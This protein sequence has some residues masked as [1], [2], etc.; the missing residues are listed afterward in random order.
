MTEFDPTG[1]LFYND[2]EETGWL[3][4]RRV[5]DNEWVFWD[6]ANGKETSFRVDDAFW[7]KELIESIEVIGYGKE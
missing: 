5:M 3:E 4:L 6:Y 1:S 2:Q 7:V